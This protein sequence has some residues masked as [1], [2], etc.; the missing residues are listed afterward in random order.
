VKKEVSEVR[1]GYKLRNRVFGVNVNK[2][3]QKMQIGHLKKAASNV[4]T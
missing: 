3:P 2:S 1:F 4:S